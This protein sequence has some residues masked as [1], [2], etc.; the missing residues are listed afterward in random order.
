MVLILIGKKLVFVINIVIL[1]CTVFLSFNVSCFVSQKQGNSIIGLY[2]RT[3]I[4]NLNVASISEHF[5]FVLIS[6]KCKKKA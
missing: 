2:I 3:K 5:R 6:T 1:V 4:D